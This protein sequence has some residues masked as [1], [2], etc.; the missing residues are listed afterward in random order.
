MREINFSDV[1]VKAGFIYF[2]V[3]ALS[4]EGHNSIMFF[5]GLAILFKYYKKDRSLS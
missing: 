2:M 4:V 3:S 5:L 1:R